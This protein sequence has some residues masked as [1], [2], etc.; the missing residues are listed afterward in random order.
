MLEVTN[1][2]KK[3]DSKYIIFYFFKGLAQIIDRVR[4]LLYFYLFIGIF[5]IYNIPAKYKKNLSYLMVV[6]MVLYKTDLLL[7]R[8]LFKYNIS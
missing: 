5:N 8:L 1:E 3:Q 7:F 2:L 4:F 6:E